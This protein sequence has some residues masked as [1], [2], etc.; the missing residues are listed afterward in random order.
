MRL[1][2]LC[3]LLAACGGSGGDDDDDDVELTLDTCTTSVAADV[4]AFYATYF[5]CSTITKTATGVLIASDALP[6][7]RSAYWGTDS[8]NYEPFDT[9][10]GPEYMQNPNLLEERP[11]EIEIPDAPVAKGLT[12]TAGDIDGM[13]DTSDDEYPLGPVG[14]ALDAV[15]L[16]NAVAAPGDDIDFERFTFDVYEAH[17]APDG[18]YH[19]HSASPGPLEV[20]TAAAI[21]AIEL[22]GILCDGT[23]VLGCTEL[24]GTAPAADLDPQG[25][26]IHDLTDADATTHFTARYHTHV[27]PDG[28]GHDYTP[29]LQY[30]STCIR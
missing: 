26:H 9:D 14:A 8:P 29:E 2:M 10:R 23:V 5:R 1:L 3:C 20:L 24:D 13:A 22:Y 27:C 11:F 19:Y 30:Y 12:I 28:G 25:G 7:H 6:P 21:P 17:P 15:A 16:F 4:P 18:T